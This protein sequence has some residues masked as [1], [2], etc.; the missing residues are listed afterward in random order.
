VTT[1]ALLTGINCFCF[2]VSVTFT[3]GEHP[4]TFFLIISVC[5][6]VKLFQ[7]HIL[8]NVVILNI[9]NSTCHDLRTTAKC[10]TP[11]PDARTGSPHFLPNQLSSVPVSG[12]DDKPGPTNSFDSSPLASNSDPHPATSKTAV[13]PRHA[14]PRYKQYLN[15]HLKTVLLNISR[16][17]DSC[18]NRFARFTQTISAQL[19]IIH[20][21][22]LN[23]DVDTIKHGTGDPL[24]VF[25]NYSRCI[26]AGLLRIPV[27]SARAGIHGG[28]QLKV[29]RK[30]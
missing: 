9:I 28:N 15:S 10:A 12:C 2:Y 18:V 21:R 11:P 27:E 6:F 30:S 17:L 13:S 7:F 14:Y 8:D 3:E 16:G 4:E 29:Y 5:Y 26:R 1:I 20:S 19:F 24:L 22:N 23:V 25:G